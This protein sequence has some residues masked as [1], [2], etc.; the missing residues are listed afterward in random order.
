LSLEIIDVSPF[1]KYFSR[2]SIQNYIELHLY[3]NYFFYNINLIYY[4]HHIIIQHISLIKLNPI[5]VTYSKNGL[6]CHCYVD[7]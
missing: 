6:E 4:I 1:A 3:T 2:V 5:F 7:Y